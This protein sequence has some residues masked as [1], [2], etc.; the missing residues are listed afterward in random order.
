MVLVSAAVGTALNLVFGGPP[1][2]ENAQVDD[3]GTGTEIPATSPST[4][5]AEIPATNPSTAPAASDS[6]SGRLF[7]GFQEGTVRKGPVD[8][9]WMETETAAYRDGPW[10]ESFIFRAMS[11]GMM[12]LFTIITGFGLH[13]L[14]MFFIGAGLLRARVF[15]R[16]RLGLHRRLFLLGLLLG[17]PIVLAGVFLPKLVDNQRL[18]VL[19]GMTNMVGGPL[20]SLGYLSAATL[21][22]A[23]G[24]LKPVVAAVARVG[25]MALTNYLTET[26]VATFLMYHWGLGWFGSVSPAQQVLIVLCVY[27]AL[28]VTSTIWLR[29]FLFGPMEWLWRTAT[30]LRPQPLLRRTQR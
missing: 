15:S 17:L 22:A 18:Y 23:S 6:P 13:V 28:L 27:A 3:A 10:I 26:V 20:M 8:P 11:F 19:M 29:F 16:D 24:M 12:I 5:P 21:I 9:I 1:P 7:A 14:G 25:R 2:T 4:A 30:Y